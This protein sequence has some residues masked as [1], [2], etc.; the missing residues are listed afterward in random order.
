MKKLIK[1]LSILLVL[2]LLVGCDIPDTTAAAAP[3]TMSDNLKANSNKIASNQ[4]KLEKA[5]PAPTIEYSNE[6]ANLIKRATTFN[7]PNK[8]S[9]IYLFTKAGTVAGF[10]TVKG[11][12]SN[13]SSYLVPDEQIVK[14]PYYDY[15][16]G[17]GGYQTAQGLVLQAPDIDGSYGSNGQGIFFYT[18]D[19]TYV[20][21]NGEYM[22]CDQPLKLSTQ[23]ILTREVK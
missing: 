3:P 5:Q 16:S 22:L 2:G 13:V 10:Y 6:R 20:E 17:S 9:Y 1:A 4:S 21:W 11:K 7:Q 15:S 18:T 23:P 12:V 14:D 8:V 19:D